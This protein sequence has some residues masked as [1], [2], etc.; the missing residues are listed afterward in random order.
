MNDFSTSYGLLT[1]TYTA[2]G[3]KPGT[4]PDPLKMTVDMTAAG[5]HVQEH[6]TLKSKDQDS[7]AHTLQAEMIEFDKHADHRYPI[8]DATIKYMAGANASHGSDR[9]ELKLLDSVYKRE[10]QLMLRFFDQLQT[11]NLSAAERTVQ[12]LGFAKLDRQSCWRSDHETH[13]ASA[14]FRNEDVNT[15]F[16]AHASR[17]LEAY[18]KGNLN[19]VNNFKI[20]FFN[21]VGYPTS[22]VDYS[23]SVATARKLLAEQIVNANSAPTTSPTASPEAGEFK[24]VDREKGDHAGNVLLP[25]Q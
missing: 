17:L 20:N 18:K 7:S 25:G 14:C 4:P 10:I 5:K 19:V 23:K 1:P 11:N 16:D 22:P 9:Y 3:A 2:L 21:A 12:L 13:I 15:T 8:G 6:M 24:V